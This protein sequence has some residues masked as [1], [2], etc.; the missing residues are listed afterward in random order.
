MN[1]PGTSEEDVDRAYETLKKD[2][3][4]AGTGSTRMRNL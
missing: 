2:A 4:M 3:T 1:V